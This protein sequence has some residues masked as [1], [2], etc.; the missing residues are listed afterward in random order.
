MNPAIRPLWRDTENFG[1]RFCGIAVTVR[2]VPTNKRAPGA[3]ARD[4]P[5]VRGKLVREALARALRRP[6]PARLGAGDRRA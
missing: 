5:F 4:V 6:A 2:Y 3:H 1:H